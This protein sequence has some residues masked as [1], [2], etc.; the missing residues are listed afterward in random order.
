MTCLSQP[1]AGPVV[2]A[3]AMLRLSTQVEA[4]PRVE[5]TTINATGN[6]LL[7]TKNLTNL[8]VMPTYSFRRRIYGQL[9]I[10][11]SL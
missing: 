11:F 3:S 8:N 4:E 1:G 10:M 6:S 5:L 9:S 2:N 7:F